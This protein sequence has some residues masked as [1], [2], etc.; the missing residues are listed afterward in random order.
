MKLSKA[1]CKKLQ[2]VC[3]IYLVLIIVLAA[4]VIYLVTK[5]SSSLKI[6]NKMVKD[7]YDSLVKIIGQPT[8]IEKCQGNNLHRHMDVSLTQIPRFW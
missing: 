7:K 8:Y 5:Q 4:A 2:T 3:G 1:N 6:P